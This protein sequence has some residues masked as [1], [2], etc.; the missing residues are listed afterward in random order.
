MINTGRF[1]YKALFTITE[2][3]YTCKEVPKTIKKSA[4]F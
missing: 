4:L 3:D 1:F 2:E